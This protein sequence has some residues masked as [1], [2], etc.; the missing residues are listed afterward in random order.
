MLAFEDVRIEAMPFFGEQP[1]RDAPGPPANVRNWGAT[2]WIETADLRI[3]VLA[4]AGADP[5]GDIADA[6]LAVAKRRGPPDVVTAC[7]RAFPSP[8]YGGLSLDWLTL[9]VD[10]L[11]DLCRL[12]HEGRLPPVTLGPAGLARVALGCGARWVAPH[13]VPDARGIISDIGWGEGEASEEAASREVQRELRALGAPARVLRWQV[14][15]R[16]KLDAAG[17]GSWVR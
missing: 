13:G 15:D 14:G 4:D 11:R 9:D 1:T 2:Y 6:V 8:V 12:H 7:L 17:L 16:A 5:A 10:R 3:A